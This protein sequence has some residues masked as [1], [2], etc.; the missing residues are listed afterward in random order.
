[1]IK[2]IIMKILVKTCT[3]NNGSHCL[4]WCSCHDGFCQCGERNKFSLVGNSIKCRNNTFSSS[5][6]LEK[7]HCLTSDNNS[8]KVYVG[9]CAY[10]TCGNFLPEEPLNKNYYLL[11]CNLTNISSYIIMW[12]VRQKRSDV[13]LL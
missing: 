9:Q 2:E 1:M 8:G 7:C 6:S 11:P 12:K 4:P 10:Y 3:C 13:W 5:S